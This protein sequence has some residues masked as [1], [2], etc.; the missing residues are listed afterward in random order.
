M[1]F[2][3]WCNESLLI[4]FSIFSIAKRRGVQKMTRMVTA[5]TEISIN[6]GDNIFYPENKLRTIQGTN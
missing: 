4:K 3:H 5:L 6:Y 2:N 1:W